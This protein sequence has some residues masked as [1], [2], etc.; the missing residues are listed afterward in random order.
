[1][2]AVRNRSAHASVV[3]SDGWRSTKTTFS[4]TSFYLHGPL[5]KAM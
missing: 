5:G 2:A 3:A 4:T 1:M